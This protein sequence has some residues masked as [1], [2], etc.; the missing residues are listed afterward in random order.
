MTTKQTKIER[1]NNCSVPFDLGFLPL[2]PSCSKAGSTKYCINCNQL[3][4]EVDL[5]TLIEQLGPQKQKTSKSLSVDAHSRDVQKEKK[6]D[7]PP[8]KEEKQG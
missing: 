4:S 2:D 8:L 5:I 3:D 7:F 6:K 1:L